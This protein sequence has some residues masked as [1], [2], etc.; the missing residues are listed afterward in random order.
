MTTENNIEIIEGN[1]RDE[2]HA[3]NFLR[4]TSAY[5]TDPMGEAMVWDD[6]QRKDVINNMKDHP[7]AVVLF[8]QAQGKFVGSCTCFYAY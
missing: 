3:E 7:C 8:A 6:Q 4:L 2:Q 5:M 1:L